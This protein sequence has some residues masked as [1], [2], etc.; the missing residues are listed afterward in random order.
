MDISAPPRP[1]FF[2][3]DEVATELRR[4]VASI[5]WMIHQ[6]QIKTGKI[7]G[8]TVVA[9]DEIDRIIAAAFDA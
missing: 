5:R 9:A 4:S 1:R 3:V 8:R 6:G 7:G 2:F